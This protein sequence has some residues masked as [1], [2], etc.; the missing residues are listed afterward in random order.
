ML[1]CCNQL[2][3]EPDSFHSMSLYTGADRLVAL[4]FMYQHACLDASQ[5][6]IYATG[7]S[8]AHRL[9]AAVLLVLLWLT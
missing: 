9:V 2:S 6:P 3:S 8:L 7:N 1:V 4:C 5:W